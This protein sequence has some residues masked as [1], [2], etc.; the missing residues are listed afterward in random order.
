[1]VWKQKKSRRGGCTDTINSNENG[2]GPRH[3][4][5]CLKVGPDEKTALNYNPMQSSIGQDSTSASRDVS[6][7]SGRSILSIMSASVSSRSRDTH[8]SEENARSNASGTSA[9]STSSAR[10][11]TDKSPQHGSTLSCASPESKAVTFGNILI[12]EHERAVGDNP[13]CSTGPPIG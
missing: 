6:I 7:R 3:L 1:M 11:S 13:S 4:R 9:G 8:V 2:S 10:N 5:S 12:R